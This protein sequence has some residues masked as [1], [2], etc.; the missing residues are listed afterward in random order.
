M[1]I[2][3]LDRLARKTID[4]LHA[5]EAL[6]GRASPAAVVSVEESIDM[7]TSIGRVVATILAAFAELEASSISAQVSAAKAY[8]ADAGR[9]SGGTVP[10]GWVTERR[11]GQPGWYLA[12]DPAASPFVEGAARLVLGGGSVYSALRW[13]ESEGAPLPTASQGSRSR[14]GWNYRTVERMLR[15][16]LL[17]GMTRR[18]DDVV[19]GPDGLPRLEEALAVVTPAER[20]QFLALLDDMTD[21]RRK[22]RP[23]AVT[24]PLLAGLAVCDGC[25]RTMTR[26]TT[27]GRASLSCP[28][29]HQTVSRPQLEELLVGRLAALKRARADLRK[30]PPA[31][32]D[33]YAWT[34][35]GLTGP[36]GLGRCR[37]RPG[38]A[39]GPRRPLEGGVLRIRRGK[40]GRYLD[41]SRVAIVWATGF[42]TIAG[43]S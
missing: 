14:A 29:C 33:A 42:P 6:Q 1:V 26:G 3:K 30:A 5:D 38:A 20:R 4:F 31:S 10:F 13:L 25:E 34:F 7:T 17:A 36:G 24:T 22:P 19:R 21:P 12:R 28:S 41:R 23:S 9:W 16:P 15:S 32:A 27:S 37:G 2:W 35:A 18:G 43:T 8:L 40:G 39:H 11:E